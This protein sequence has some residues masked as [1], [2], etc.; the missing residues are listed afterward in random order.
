[1]RDETLAL[2]DEFAAAWARGET[3]DPRAL[4]AR[5]PERDRD[6]LAR[7]LDRYLAGAPPRAA[8]EESRAFVA[9]IA[10]EAE[11][12]AEP[13]LLALRLERRLTRD[14]VVEGLMSRLGLD[15]AKRAKVRRYFS[16][17]EVGVLDPR[18]VA[19]SV[20]EALGQV[21]G[22]EA[23]ATALLRSEGVSLS[24][25]QAYYRVTD[26]SEPGEPLP[27]A[28]VPDVAEPDEIDRLFTGAR[29]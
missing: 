6:E 26:G 3:P 24:I 10:A 11:S 21:L 12:A 2:L 4:L 22:G 1:M 8:S 29:D 13:P 18:G 17:L 27:A 25:T 7:A 15:P 14:A 5:A 16:D 20:W 23:L 28:P 9:A 19:A